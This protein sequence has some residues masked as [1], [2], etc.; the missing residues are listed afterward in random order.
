MVKPRVLGATASV[1]GLG[2]ALLFG[3]EL[4]LPIFALGEAFAQHPILVPLVA[5]VA[6]G[7]SIPFIH[8]GSHVE[9]DGT[10]G[11]VCKQ[12]DSVFRNEEELKRHSWGYHET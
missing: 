6:I 11:C 2:A 4:A 9:S 1:I 12:C 5:L 3:P 7:Q 8:F 10:P